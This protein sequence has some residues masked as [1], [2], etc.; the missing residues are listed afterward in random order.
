MNNHTFTNWF[1]GA[2]NHANA[3]FYNTHPRTNNLLYLPTY[4][5]THVRGLIPSDSGICDG[6]NSCHLTDR[7]TGY[8]NNKIDSP[9][10]QISDDIPILNP[11]VP[12][13]LPI[14]LQSPSSIYKSTFYHQNA[15]LNN[16][17][18]ARD[19]NSIREAYQS[20]L[21][22]NHLHPQLQLMRE[23]FS[24]TAELNYEPSPIGSLSDNQNTPVS[25]EISDMSLPIEHE[26]RTNSSIKFQDRNKKL[27]FKVNFRD[28]NRKINGCFHIEG[29][30]SQN[31]LLLASTV[32]P[33]KKKWIRHYLTGNEGS[34]LA[35]TC[36]YICGSLLGLG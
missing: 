22:H 9:L 15:V 25:V 35:Q 12:M 11:Y 3:L 6:M 26:E 32:A 24:R 29:S 17:Y 23:G 2:P 1:N 14:E 31:R 33:P 5:N 8:M 21:L 10:N 20:P 18:A 7:W 34:S 30:K 19:F 13:R 36:A 28:E 27:D 16:V 4:R